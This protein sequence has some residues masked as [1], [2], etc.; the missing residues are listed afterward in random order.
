MAVNFED[1]KRA[2]VADMRAHGGTITQGPMAG[3]PLLILTTTGAKSGETREAIVTYTRD[4]ERY[5]I[6][7]SKG[8]APTNP[9]WYYN[10]KAN[11]IA[12]VEAGGEVFKAR[13]TEAV[14]DERERLWDQHVAQRPEF[15]EYPKK[16]TRK[17]PVFV[18]DRLS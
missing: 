13:A 11:P 5:V 4:G 12:D 1:Y 18:L 15:G 8:G 2:L 16:T 14:G 10:L 17:I 6:C 9:A 7:A 3:R